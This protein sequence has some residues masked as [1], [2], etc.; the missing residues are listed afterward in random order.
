MLIGLFLVILFLPSFNSFTNKRIEVSTHNWFQMLSIAFMIA[1]IVGVVA[2]GYPALYLSNLKPASILKGRFTGKTNTWFAKP[3]VVL[4]FALSA[5]LIMYNQMKFI[6]TKD[7]G[8]D[9]H[10]VLF[11]PTQ[12]GGGQRSNRFVEN[13]RSA[14]SSDP[15]VESVAGTSVPFTYGTM[16]MGFKHG[17]EF[18]IASGYIVD[19]A[20]IPM[21]EIELMVGRNFD[22]DNPADADGVIVNE[23]PGKGLE[24]DRGMNS[25]LDK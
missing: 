5:F 19:P 23:A 20:Y 15:Q 25:G 21:F 14:V 4:L 1:C 6:T 22:V 16:T 11:I 10:Q 18:K 2:G 3:L 12:Q 9:Q 17:D 13:F 7:L 8:Y 24:M